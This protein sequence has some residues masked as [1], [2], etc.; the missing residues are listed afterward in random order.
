MTAP[1]LVWLR[2]DL[3][4]SDNPALTEAAKRGPVVLAYIH[5]DSGPWPLGGARRWWLHQSLEALDRDVR[6]RGGLLLVRRGKAEQL[7]PALARDIRAETVFWNRRW[8]PEERRIETA[9][10]QRLREDG[11][12]FR[13]HPASL[14]FEPGKVLSREGRPL[15]V[16]TAFWRA[17]LATAAPLPPLPAPS[18]LTAPAFAPG[19]GPDQGVGVA[20]LGLMPEHDWWRGLAQAWRPGETQALRAL[21]EFL[22]GPIPDY[23]VRRDFPARPATS[24]LS[25][26]LAFGEITPRQIWHAVQTRPPS[27]GADTFLKEVGWREFSY[28]LLARHTDLAETPLHPEFREFP[29]CEDEAQ[30]E[31]WR[32]GKTGYPIVDAGMRELWATGWMHNRVRMIAASFLVKDLLLPWQLGQS[33]FWDTLVDAD[34]ANN[35]ASWQW[36]AGCGADAA[37]YFRVFN[38]VLQGEKFDPCGQ[39][40]RRWI[41][42]LRH[43]P[44]ALIH[45][46]WQAPRSERPDAYPA[47]IVDHATARDRALAAL[48]R[49]KT[50]TEQEASQGR[51]FP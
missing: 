44:D 8:E 28:S 27:A 1:S 40:V 15:Q 2:Q 19:R 45:K 49:H 20:D 7:V 10:A 38:P 18:H 5:D 6:A 31:A 3:R 39:Y 24:R 14:L 17:A 50:A 26:H 13:D 46:P 21:Q 9:V 4:L 36:V 47:P 22:D 29:W 42:E 35:A 32:R 37:P 41:P 51:L 34:L 33:W 43:L 16:F 12:A 30:A 25:P 23:A 11:V 48:K